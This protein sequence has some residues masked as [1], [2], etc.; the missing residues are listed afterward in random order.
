MNAHF[1]G[2]NQPKRMDPYFKPLIDELL[3][4]WQGMS[5]KDV[6]R[7]IGSRIFH[8]HPI[9]VFTIHDALGLSMCCGEL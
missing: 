4:F 9:L 7:P 8:F 5:M 3:M 6:S 1:T 2:T